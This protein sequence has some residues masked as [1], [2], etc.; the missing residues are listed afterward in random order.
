VLEVYVLHLSRDLAYIVGVAPINS[1]LCNTFH[2]IA[3][4]LAN[5]AAWSIIELGIGLSA[6]SAAALRPLLHLIS[7]GSLT[8]STRTKSGRNPT[9][10]IDKTAITTG[11]EVSLSVLVKGGKTTS[12]GDADSQRAMLEEEAIFVRSEVNVKEEFVHRHA[13]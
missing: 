1:T 7:G 3:D 9:Y 12:V 13:I 8:N 4:G 6:G 5:I 11:K 10:A 2:H